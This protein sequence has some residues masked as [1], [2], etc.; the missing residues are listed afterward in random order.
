MRA[1]YL[2]RLTGQLEELFDW[3]TILH[4]IFLELLLGGCL[5]LLFG[6]CSRH[7]LSQFLLHLGAIYNWPL[8]LGLLESGRVSKGKAGSLGCPRC[9][10]DVL[11]PD[12]GRLGGSTLITNRDLHLV[13]VNS[14]AAL[15]ITAVTVAL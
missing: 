7:T 5:P 6:L 14:R 13:M 11:G 1:I 2:N 15:N 3:V 10:S 9:L 4:V 12:H 8:L